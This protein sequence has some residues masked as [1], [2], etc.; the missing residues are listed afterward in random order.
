MAG[1]MSDYPP[2]DGINRKRREQNTIHTVL[3][4]SKALEPSLLN[5]FQGGV[6]VL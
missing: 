2:L 3:V 5:D 4:R 6:A 1:K